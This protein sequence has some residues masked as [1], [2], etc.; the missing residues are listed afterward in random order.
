[1][2]QMFNKPEYF[3]KFEPI[4]CRISNEYDYKTKFHIDTFSTFKYQNRRSRL[5][6]EIINMIMNQVQVK[7]FYVDEFEC[8]LEFS[9]DNQ[10]QKKLTFFLT[11]KHYYTQSVFMQKVE[12]DYVLL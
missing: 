4:S 11:K 1:M 7:I 2:L 5:Y 9:F 10:K 6:Y 12:V 3:N 8:K